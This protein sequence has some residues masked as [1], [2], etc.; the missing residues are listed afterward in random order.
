MAQERPVMDLLNVLLE[1]ERAGV[2]VLGE[3]GK[4]VDDPGLK[5]I[6]AAFKDDEAHY[7]AG[8]VKLIKK[9]GGMP[10]EKTGDFVGKVMA[11][12][13]LKAQL[14]LLNRGQMWVAKRIEERLND[15]GD[16]ETR[17]FLTEMA[18]RHRKN[19]A[20]CEGK[21]RELYGN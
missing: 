3:L 9:H 6:V 8:L 10:S 1:A 17:A 12:S 4:K 13:E 21:L 15:V 2:K 5:S 18:Q 19:V 20:T 11:L 16:A 14:E 7:C